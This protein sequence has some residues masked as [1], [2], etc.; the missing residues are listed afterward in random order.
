LSKLASFVLLWACL[1]LAYGPSV[2]LLLT[3]ISKRSALLVLS[4]FSAFIWF[5][6][7]LLTSLFWLVAP[8]TIQR[9]HIYA[10][11]ISV[12]IQEGMRYALLYLYTRII[13]TA[14]NMDRNKLDRILALALSGRSIRKPKKEAPLSNDF[15]AAIGSGLGYGLMH[16]I[17]M[18]GGVI[19]ASSDLEGWYRVQCPTLNAF[20]ASAAT[21]LLYNI[22]HIPLMIIALDAYRRWN[23]QRALIPS[24]IHLVFAI[25]GTL[26]EGTLGEVGCNFTFPALV[27]IATLAIFIAFFTYSSKDYASKVQIN[28]A[29]EDSIAFDNAFA[30]NQQETL[31]E[32]NTAVRGENSVRN[33]RINESQAKVD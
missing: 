19:S 6:S 10:I 17:M 8:S 2:A 26:Q 3:F 18:Y 23:W 5:L 15:E 33:R 1:F 31:V 20:A 21:A 11:V 24:I 27:L 7:I 32:S 14:E 29:L 30:F 12:I 4:V 28:R 22:L 16:T 9:V 25:S 13:E